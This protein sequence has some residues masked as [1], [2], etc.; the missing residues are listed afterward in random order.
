MSVAPVP[1]Q[2]NRLLEVKDLVIEFHLI[3]GIVPAVNGVSL[4]VERG[5][6]LGIVGES[7]CGKSVTALRHPA[8][9]YP[10]APGKVVGG[11]ILFHRWSTDETVDL[12]RLPP[13]AARDTQNP[14]Q[15]DRHDLPGADDV[16]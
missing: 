3:D 4:D 2:D 6:T 7:G 5:K 15:R 13:M 14:R 16:A 9:W 12:T 11:Q 10:I 8:G 1:A